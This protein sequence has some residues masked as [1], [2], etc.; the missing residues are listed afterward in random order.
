[1]NQKDFRI[2]PIG[3]IFEE[4][5]R[6]IVKID[7]KFCKGLKNL[8]L[9][10][11]AII[12]YKSNLTSNILNTDLSQKVV[13]LE[14][15]DEKKGLL[16]IGN[17][18]L[19]GKSI[20]Y[21]I[22]PYF[23]NEDR[24]KDATVPTVLNI[25]VDSLHKQLL[26]QMGTV[27]KTKGCYYLEVSENFDS[28]IKVLQGYSHIKIIWWFHKF[29][30]DIYKRTLESVPP[31]EGAPKTGI[32]ASRS[33][34][35]PN[36]LAVTTA[37]ILGIDN[38]LKRIKVSLLDCFD[39]TPFLGISPYI[40]EDDFVSS[41]R[42][43]SWLEHWSPYH[44][45]RDFE[46]LKLPTLS[47]TSRD[48]INKTALTGNGELEADFFTNIEEQT[49]IINREIE[50]KGARQNNLK[51][52]NVTI[53]YN[54]TTVITGVSGSGKSS[55]AFDTIFAESQQ[56]F[57]SSMSL[58]ERSSFSLMEKP[59]FDYI[60]GLPPAIAI[61]Q[62]LINRNPRST[63][64]TAT[65]LYNLL[66]TLYANIGVRHCPECG[67]AIDKMIIEEI[68][69]CLK[70]CKQGTELRILPFG[71]PDLTKTLTV[72]SSNDDNYEEYIEF[73][74]HTVRECIA[75]GIGALVVQIDNGEK[76]IFQTT[77]KCYNC[78]HILFELTA[79]DFSFNNPESMCSVCNGFGNVTDID[80]AL[81]IKYPDKS[82]LD[83]ASPFWGDLRKFKETPNANW[84]KGEVLALASEAGIDLEIPWKDLP[85]SFKTL[86]IYGTGDREVTFSY[87]N[88]NGR[89][90]SITRPAEGAYNIL[91]R[92]LSSTTS[93]NGHSSAEEFM[94]SKLCESCNGERLKI[95]SRIVTV[96][97]RR[98][99]EVIN[100]T[101]EELKNW[102]SSLSTYL[103]RSDETLMR[104]LLQ[105]IYSKVSLYITIGLDYLTLD[106]SITTLSGG[107][108]QRLKLVSQLNSELSNILY[109]LDEPTAGLHP[110]D[111]IKL[112]NII[113]RLKNQNNTIVI[114]E[115]SPEIMKAADNI[116][117]IGPSAG[118]YGG[119]VLAQGTPK[120]IMQNK[121]SE[122]GQYLA[123]TKAVKVD[124]CIYTDE[125]KFWVSLNGVQ[126]NN[127][128]NIDITFPLNAITCITGVSG[129][130]KS[131]L[132]NW[133]IL[134]AVYS[135]IDNVIR[136]DR[137][138]K[139]IIGADK[140]GKIIHVTQKPIG[141]SSRSTPATYTG[142]MDELRSIFIGIQEAIEHGYSLGKFSYNTKDGQCPA[143]LGYGYKTLDAAFM[144]STK[145]QCPLCK[146]T[147]FHS[148][149]LQIFYKG[150]NIA[151]ILEMSV[152]EA[153]EYFKEHKKLHTILQTLHEI[154]LGYI[155]LG[156]SSQ[157]LSGG[158]ALR[159]KLA[160]ELAL[161]NS[162]HTLYLLDEPTSGLHFSDIQNLLHILSKIIQKGNTV[163]LVEHNLDVIKNADWIIDLGP[164]G[165]S[166]GGKLVVQ[167]T[168]S[169]VVK[170]T[171]SHTGKL[172]N[173]KS[174]KSLKLTVGSSPPAT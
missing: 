137:K 19:G 81:I 5:K 99:P 141:R 165:G 16:T 163:I 159:I 124:R 93:E 10:S 110:K 119:Y 114:V 171:D 3:S 56:R 76:L 105:E 40:P 13:K 55:L 138:Y 107:E 98:F 30:K 123:G 95:E 18:V 147:K 33:P 115:H 108:A 94:V 156:Q 116:I 131:S 154:G 26:S 145:I 12:I 46:I 78:D 1:M 136:S 77:E 106:R 32:F 87:K 169:D 11:H 83:S 132:V 109:I 122:T 67:Y 49:P 14:L 79:S 20:L 25:N 111:Y 57:L 82:I 142:I 97:N 4:N 42:L 126:G 84:M 167:G 160:T 36:P 65:D 153:L 158:E 21:D 64:G 44:D 166:H 102:I 129:S 173:G 155:A 80:A 113:S 45:D 62:N 68:I 100:M 24:V 7:S 29:E 73:L 112:M 128:Q 139:E 75:K 66:R 134:P 31:Y 152:T 53:P 117:D 118:V 27:R 22:K 37:K 143:C 88:R 43:P 60:S 41:Y 92:L 104:S 48:V 47:E 149:T 8:S 51:N 101:M 86:T 38:V 70:S 2:I 133:G 89:T 52:I 72:L 28:Y 59:D 90:G 172:L 157:S 71:K 162:K 164:G 34:V 140:I 148:T 168:V 50:I 144:P 23:P 151:Q 35:R 39:D 125:D 170:C 150:K 15:V 17:S 6:K 63:V 58:S 135:C 54:K 85:E 103:N 120:E 91:K 174:N 146:G 9:F 161:N 127:L 130:G 121:Q 74:D 61:S 69:E 96:A